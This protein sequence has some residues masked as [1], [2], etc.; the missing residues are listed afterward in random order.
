MQL[1][2]FLFIVFFLSYTALINGQEKSSMV[3]S[4]KE[5]NFGT[6]RAVDGLITH[7]FVF[8]NQGKVPLI[9]NDVKSTCGCT[10]P[11]WP[12]E[13]VLPGKSGKI[14]VSFNPS[15]QSG[16]V[17]K[18]IRILSNASNSPVALAV[19]GVVIPAE[20][21]EETYKFTIGDIR[22][23][24]IYAAFGEIYKGRSARYSIKVFNTNQEQ[25]AT[26][27]FRSIPAHLKIT[28]SPISIAPQ[29]EGILELEYNSDLIHSWDYT[30]D[31]LD[32]LI[33]GKVVPNNRINVTATIKED[34]SALTAEQLSMAARAE[35]DSH[36]H[37]FGSI[38]ADRIVEHIFVLTNTGKSDLHIRKVSASCG[39]TAVQPAKTTVL[40]GESTEI[41]AVFNARGREG[42]Q[43]KAITVITNDPRQTRSILWI[44]AV[45]QKPATN[46]N[47]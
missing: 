19:R 10:V 17:N 20:K 43:K 4:E 1:K 28:A 46:M 38:T 23:E 9:L 14:S 42:N 5:L 26:L 22:L 7:D 32:L 41:K 36:Q 31:R 16:A 27:T 11:E 33:N 12:R 40:P 24:T 35:F 13:P 18:T 29:Q 8:T 25:P 21:V 37:N 39:C 30:V 15:G 3:F 44:N 34:F 2:T 47:P 45:V 6:V